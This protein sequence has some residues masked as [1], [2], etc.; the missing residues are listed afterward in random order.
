[1][2]MKYKSRLVHQY[3]Q[4]LEFQANWRPSP[5]IA[6]TLEALFLFCFHSADVLR[7]AAR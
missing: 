4:V 1:M 6:D 5:A 2:Q 7:I 3:I